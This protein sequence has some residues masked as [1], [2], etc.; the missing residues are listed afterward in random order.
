MFPKALKAIKTFKA[1]EAGLV[2]KTAEKN[3]DAASY[4]ELLRKALPLKVTRLVGGHFWLCLRHAR[5]EIG[6]VANSV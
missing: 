4:L 5:S 2:P 1:E 6:D 3:N